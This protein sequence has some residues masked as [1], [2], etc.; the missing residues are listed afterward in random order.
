M[1]PVAVRVAALEGMQGMVVALD[2]AGVCSIWQATCEELQQ[3]GVE[4]VAG[5]EPALLDIN[6][7]QHTWLAEQ[8]S[9]LSAAA[10]AGG[11]ALQAAL[12][13][14]RLGFGSPPSRCFIKTKLVFAAAAATTLL[15]LLLL[16][17]PCRE[18]GSAVPR[19]RAPKAVNIIRRI[20]A[21]GLR[22]NGS[23]A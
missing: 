3:Y 1:L 23:R 10:A 19:Q 6:L 18:A 15:L 22:S 13:M 14:Q 9:T 2:D 20:Q 11:G 4:L 8:D 5:H 21:A 16:C 12:P 17:V 7:C